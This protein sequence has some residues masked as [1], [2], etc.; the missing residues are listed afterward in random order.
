M[1]DAEN[2]IMLDLLCDKFVYGLD[3]NESKQLSE[4]GFA[5]RE[6]DSIE[7]TIAALG[8]VDLDAEAAMPAHL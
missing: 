4:L 7:Q 2:E 6:A 8:L 1:S 3:A 5:A